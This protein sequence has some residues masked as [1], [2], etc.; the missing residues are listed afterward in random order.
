MLVNYYAGS[1]SNKK[2][3]KKCL[4]I[5][6]SN[7]M[8]SERVR[9]ILIRAKGHLL[10]TNPLMCYFPPQKQIYLHLHMQPDKFLS[11]QTE[12][13][14]EHSARLRSSAGRKLLHSHMV[15]C[16]CWALVLLGISLAVSLNPRIKHRL[17]KC[18]WNI[19]SL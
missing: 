18:H 15:W 8:N 1:N 17:S 19:S 6:Y 11:R 4:T 12:M 7:Q 3:T 16:W 14:A 10:N 9:F 2:T 13:T 5:K